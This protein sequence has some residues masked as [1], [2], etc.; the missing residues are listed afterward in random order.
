MGST[1]QN[2][3]ELYRALLALPGGSG[4]LQTDEIEIHF[5]VD[6]TRRLTVPHCLGYGELVDMT[7]KMARIWGIA[8]SDVQMKC[9]IKGQRICFGCGVD[10]DV[11]KPALE[12]LDQPGWLSED[13]LCFTCKS[14]Q[15]GAVMDYRS[16]LQ[17]HLDEQDKKT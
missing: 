15:T 3:R 13:G 10:V 17:R 9:N 16:D 12:P 2:I 1:R 11:Y 5:F 7:G 4:D 6:D 8:Q 14:I